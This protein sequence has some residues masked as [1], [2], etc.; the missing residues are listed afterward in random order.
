LH[1]RPAAAVLAEIAELTPLYADAPRAW[2][3]DSEGVRVSAQAADVRFEFA[4]AGGAIGEDVG[5]T[6][7]S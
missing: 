4:L 1:S 7:G 3:K 2:A 6:E 5:E